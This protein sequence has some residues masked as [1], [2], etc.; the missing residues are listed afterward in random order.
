[1]KSLSAQEEFINW[2]RTQNAIIVSNFNNQTECKRQIAKGGNFLKQVLDETKYY[3]RATRYHYV[4][5]NKIS[6][7][8]QEEQANAIAKRSKKVETLFIASSHRI[9]GQRNIYIFSSLM[10]N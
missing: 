5:Y 1:M 2:L 7:G 6:L 3:E 8:E 4:V 10:S 9:Q